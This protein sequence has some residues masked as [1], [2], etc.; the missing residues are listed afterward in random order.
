MVFELVQGAVVG[1]GGGCD[2]WTQWD[3][4][5]LSPPLPSLDIQIQPLTP[6][7][8]LVSL[9]T[10]TPT[11]LLVLHPPPGPTNSITSTGTPNNSTAAHGLGAQAITSLSWAP[12]CGRSY[13]LLASGHRDGT[14]R[15][16]KV[17]PPAAA[18]GEH[19]AEEGRGRAWRAEVAAEWGKG[20]VMVG[21]VEVGRLR[22]VPLTRADPPSSGI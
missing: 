9:S 20:D 11:A 7:P 4:Q 6:L 21:K 19:D 12:S 22:L 15:I 17:L 2:E 10:T 13:H 5:G 1:T 3:Y 16:W 14:V 18:A 8:Q